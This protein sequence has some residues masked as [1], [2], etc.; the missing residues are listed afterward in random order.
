MICLEINLLGY[1]PTEGELFCHQNALQIWGASRFGMC[2][3]NCQEGAMGMREKE[4]ELENQQP[5]KKTTENSNGERE[6]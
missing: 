1:L 3:W 6:H 5:N 2:T 4:R